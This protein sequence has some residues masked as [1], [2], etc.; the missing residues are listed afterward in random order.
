MSPPPFSL[1]LRQA[2][3]GKGIFPGL[4]LPDRVQFTGGQTGGDRLADPFQISGHVLAVL[5]GAEAERL[6]KRP[7]TPGVPLTTFYCWNDR[8]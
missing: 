1:C 4:F 3:A 6:H 7:D 8:F 2:G 5:P